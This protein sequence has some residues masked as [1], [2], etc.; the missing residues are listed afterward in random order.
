M[1]L[2]GMLNPIFKKYVLFGMVAQTVISEKMERI[3]EILVYIWGVSTIFGP[4]FKGIY[5][6]EW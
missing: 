1:L 5:F 6:L 3:C 4:I 2:S